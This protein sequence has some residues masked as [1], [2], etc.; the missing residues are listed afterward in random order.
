MMSFPLLL[1]DELKGFYKSKVMLFLWVGL[2]ALSMLLYLATSGSGGMSLATLT[3]ILVGSVGGVLS[4]VMLVVSIVSERERHV[5][6]LFVIRP[7]KRRDL[8]LSKFLA[9]YACVAAAGALAFSVASLAEYAVD[10]SLP[11]D[12]GD[13]VLSFFVVAFSMMAISC[14]AGLLIGVASPSV[15][16]GVILVIYGANQLS[17]SVL[18]PVMN[19]SGEPLFPLV[20]G[21]LI[22]ALLLLG[23]VLLFDRRQL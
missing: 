6:D 3:A 20:P 12:F 16:V 2:P 9:V 19:T 8:I 15:L 22:S 7:I 11:P 10:G 18:I 1:M 17:A 5:Y 21:V 4:S 23:A 13:G 14:S